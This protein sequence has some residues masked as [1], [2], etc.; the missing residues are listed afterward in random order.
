M[1]TLMVVG[2]GALVELVAFA[3]PLGGAG[4]GGN[5]CGPGG[6]KGEGHE[7]GENGEGLEW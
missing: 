4:G 1:K 3:L 6:R 5:I 7:G 2:G